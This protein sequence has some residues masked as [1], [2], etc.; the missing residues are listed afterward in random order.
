[1]K[2]R[3]RVFNLAVLA[4]GLLALAFFLNELGWDGVDQAFE[5]GGWFAV[6]AAIDL[7]SV[8][9]DAFAVHGYL[10]PRVRVSYPRVLGAQASGLA[11]NRLTPGNSLGEPVKVTMLVRYVPVD[12]A[13]SAIV[14]FNLTTY[15]VA[16]AALVIGVPLTATLLDLPHQLAIAVWLA[17][18]V[19]DVV[20]VALAVVVRR[21]AVGTIIDGAVAIR[22]V[23]RARGD[24]WHARIA[25]IDATVR[26]L[27][28]PESGFR[29]GL[30]GVVGSRLLNWTGT[31]VVLHA[32]A[33]TLTLP[34]VVATLS[35]GILVTWMTN[36][37]PLGLGIADGANYMLYDLLGATSKAGLLFTMVNRLRTVVLAILGLAIMAIANAVYRSEPHDE[38]VAGAAPVQSGEAP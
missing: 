27:G 35:V 33:I 18:G 31:I 30:A 14:M 34:L 9:C 36:V 11:I 10:R 28:R 22:V 4:V 21:G 24:R 6:L 32:C 17:A 20:A 26:E 29:R 7:A 13:V 12:A 23:S 8:L 37:I 19:L 25:T 2:R 3:A 15:Y 38:R 1:M 16:I 5:V